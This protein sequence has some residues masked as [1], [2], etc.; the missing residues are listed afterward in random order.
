MRITFIVDALGLECLYEL[1]LPHSRQDTN[2][3]SFKVQCVSLAV[4]AIRA[5]NNYQV[6]FWVKPS[7]PSQH[8]YNLNTL[9]IGM[10]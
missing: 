6:L 2:L 3:P 1:G 10:D 4:P 7:L 9:A 5:I 8:N